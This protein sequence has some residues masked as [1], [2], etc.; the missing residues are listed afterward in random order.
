MDRFPVVAVL[1]VRPL[2]LAERARAVELTYSVWGTVPFVL[3]FNHRD[4]VIA[5]FHSIAR[6]CF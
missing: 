2:L 6:Y 3:S 4:W 5:S 1:L